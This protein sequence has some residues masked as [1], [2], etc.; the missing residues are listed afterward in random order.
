MLEQNK[1]NKLKRDRAVVRW[2]VSKEIHMRPP[3]E[4]A[5]DAP[6]PDKVQT[7]MVSATERAMGWGTYLWRTKQLQGNVLT[8]IDA[9]F[10]GQQNKAVKD[11]IKS[12]FRDGLTSAQKYFFDGVCETS[13]WPEY[14]DD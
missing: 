5:T 3:S 1:S 8:V 13:T 4:T 10:T 11:L 12:Y 7:P 14:S 2:D 9:S 6:V